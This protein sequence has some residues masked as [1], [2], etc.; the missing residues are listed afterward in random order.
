MA[1]YNTRKYNAQRY[2]ING[3]F[4]ASS[5]SETMTAADATEMANLL[6]TL[7]DS[8]TL[9]SSIIFLD[10]IFLADF[11]FMDDMIQIQFTNKALNDTIRLADWLSIER[12]PVNNEWFN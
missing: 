7:S 11:T 4:Y 10:S 3:I 2:N 12:N 6:K 8:L 9:A 1:K 5:F